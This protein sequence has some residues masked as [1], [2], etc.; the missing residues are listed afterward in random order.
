MANP[1][2][3]INKPLRAHLIP[4]LLLGYDPKNYTIRFKEWQA[5]SATYQ[6]T[7][8]QI[9]RRSPV[10]HSRT[11][12]LHFGFF[13][14]KIFC[15]IICKTH[16]KGYA[17]IILICTTATSTG[18]PIIQKVY[19]ILDKK[20]V[21]KSLSIEKLWSCKECPSSCL[22]EGFCANHF[23]CSCAKPIKIWR[24]KRKTSND[25]LNKNRIFIRSSVSKLAI[26][27]STD[28]RLTINIVKK[29]TR[30]IKNLN[31]KELQTTNVI[32]N[33]KAF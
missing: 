25:I 4:S 2:L 7:V 32:Y 11:V 29:L 16:R 17:I 21:G 8:F 1:D 20:L 30:N 33:R 24:S 13:K 22:N 26:L 3:Q 12:V 18:W 19:Y 31:P 15:L 14:V 27:D 5:G 6:N 10:K 9:F 23:V 28:F